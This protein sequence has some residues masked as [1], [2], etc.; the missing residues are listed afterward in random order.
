MRVVLAVA[1]ILF[2]TAQAFAQ[3]CPSTTTLVVNSSQYSGAFNIELRR[4]NRPGS[5]VVARRTLN[6]SGTI[7]VAQVCAGT[8]FFAFGT[9]DSDEVSVTRYF[10]V[11]DDGNTYSNPVITVFYSRSTNDGSQRVASAKRKSL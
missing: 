10:N 6:G 11:R 5:T 9:P 8:Y 3:A 4:G 2:A 7:K 1:A